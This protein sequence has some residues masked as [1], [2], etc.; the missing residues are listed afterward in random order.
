MITAEGH[1][2][3]LLSPVTARRGD[4]IA[5]YSHAKF[6]FLNLDT[7][8]APPGCLNFKAEPVSF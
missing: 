2:A 1:A 7:T 6:R 8:A 5:G 4:R 3:L